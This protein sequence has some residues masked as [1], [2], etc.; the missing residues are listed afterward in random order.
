MLNY[1]S[2]LR[3]GTQHT[4]THSANILSV[5]GSDGGRYTTVS[6][7]L[8]KYYLGTIEARGTFSKHIISGRQ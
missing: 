6:R 2:M 5:A 8:Q 7:I 1:I 4:H 3:K